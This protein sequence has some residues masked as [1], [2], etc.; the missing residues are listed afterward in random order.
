MLWWVSSVLDW[1]DHFQGG[2][3]PLPLWLKLVGCFLRSFS[4]RLNF[5]LG[6]GQCCFHSKIPPKF[7]RWECY[8]GRLESKN[9][10]LISSNLS[11]LFSKL[12]VYM[13]LWN[14]SHLMFQQE[15]ISYGKEGTLVRS[16]LPMKSEK[17]LHRKERFS[18]RGR[19]CW[20]QPQLLHHYKG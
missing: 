18:G 2:D 16:T 13:Q 19:L 15:T 9:I 3:A 10:S 5:K 7:S 17:S 8:V 11:G 14:P 20:S 12:P 1:Q 4:A 6:M